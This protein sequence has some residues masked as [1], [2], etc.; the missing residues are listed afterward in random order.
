MP[1][2]FKISY[3]QSIKVIH[4]H[5]R[6]IFSYYNDYNVNQYMKTHIQIAQNE[7]KQAY[8][9]VIAHKLI[10]RI[11][12]EAILCSSRYVVL[13]NWHISSIGSQISDQISSKY[14]S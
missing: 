1:M 10:T 3:H 4:K 14:V 5:I 6:L 13:N 2:I 7:T 8:I 11:P 12:I 9:L